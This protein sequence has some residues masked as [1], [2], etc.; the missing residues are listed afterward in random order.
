MSPI[1]LSQV[2]LGKFLRFTFQAY[3]VLAF[4]LAYSFVQFTDVS[5][6]ASYYEA[7]A[8]NHDTC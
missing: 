3:V 6:S 8:G 2:E 4:E 5:W 1:L 7:D